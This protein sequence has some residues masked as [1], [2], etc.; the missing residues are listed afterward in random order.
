MVHHYVHRR[1][2][3]PG[4]SMVARWGIVLLLLAGLL[5]GCGPGPKQEPTPPAATAVPQPPPS[6]TPQAAT[7]SP[8]NTQ[9]VVQP[10]PTAPP[11]QVARQPVQVTILHTNDVYGEIEPCG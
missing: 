1:P 11:T 3:A 7:L 9:V 8:T 2:K 6:P 4:L 5:S 10:S